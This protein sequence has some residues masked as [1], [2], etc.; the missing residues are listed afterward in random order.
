MKYNKMQ[1]DPKVM[2]AGEYAWLVKQTCEEI[3]ELNRKHRK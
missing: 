3:E 1:I 2:T